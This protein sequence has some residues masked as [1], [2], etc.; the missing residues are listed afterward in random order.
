M[1]IVIDMQGAQSE[2]RFRGIG[3]YTLSFAQA[4]VRNRG[5]HEVILALSGLFP[6][7]IEPIRGAFE[8]LMPSD[9]IRVWSAP[10]PVKESD[11]NNDTRREVAEIMRE[12]FL[13]SL[14]PDLIHI[15]SV[16][17]GYLDDA[18]ISIGRF[19][20]QTPVSVTLHDLIPLLNP[21]QY[22][23]PDPQYSKYYY[24]KIESIQ[25]AHTYLAISESSREEGVMTLGISKECM[26]NTSE[27]ADSRF[28]PYILDESTAARIRRKF[29]LVQPFVLYT[30]G[31]DDRKN[32]LRLIT[33]YAR[34]PE[35]LRIKYQLL[36]AGKMPDEAVLGFKRHAESEGLLPGD[37]IFTGYIS[38]DELI[39]LYNLCELFV[40]PSWH[41]GFGLPALEAMACG[42][43]VIGANTSSLPE[44]IGLNSALFDPFEADS[45]SAKMAEVLNDDSYRNSLIDH[46]LRQAKK[47]SWDKTAK[48]A[49]DIWERAQK[50]FECGSLATAG[51]YERLNMVVSKY[52]QKMD[53]E[54]Q[55]EIAQDLALNFQQSTERQL[56]VDVSE[57]CQRDAATGIQRVVK[58]YLKCLLELP[59]SGYRV[60]PI[61][62]T[63]QEDG[64]RYAR[65]FKQRFLGENA[66]CVNDDP[67]HWQRG[68]VFLGLDMQHHVQLAHADYYKQLQLDGV[69]FKFL[70]HDLLPLQLQEYFDGSEVG[71]LHK[72]LLT[73]IASLDGAICVSKATSEA[74]E[75]W[76]NDND[77][78]RHPSFQNT[79]VHNGA[80]IEGPVFSLGMPEG[81]EQVL[82]EL[83]KRPTFLCV[84]TLEPRKQQQQILDAAQ[85]LWRGEYD[86]NLVFVGSKGWK[87]EGLAERIRSHPEQGRR[88]F[89]LEAISDEYLKRVYSA[90][91]CLIAASVNEGFG[92]S[93]V[94]AAREGIPIVARDIPVFREVADSGAY[95]FNG[96]TPEDLEKALR[97][98]LALYSNGIHPRSE[99][100]RWS[101]WKES[102]EKLKRALLEDYFPRRQLLVD[103]SEL[104]HQDARSGIQRVVRSIVKEWLD[105]P[106][107][108]FR[109]ELVYATLDQQYRYARRFTQRFLGRDDDYSEDEII[110]YSAE[111]IFFALDL[112]PQVTVAQR[113][114]FRKLRS[115]GVK[116]YFTVYDLLCILQPDHFL[117]GSAEG[118]SDWLRVVSES[119]GAFCISKA[120]ANEF[121]LWMRE[122]IV[123]P[124]GN[125]NVEWF[126]LG[127]DLDNSVP[128]RGFPA[129]AE[130]VLSR[131]AEQ[132]SFLMV[133]TVEPRKGHK[134][135]LSA[136]E[137]IW[138]SGKE[139]NLVIVGK[140]GWMVE[141]L[142]EVMRC[143]PDLGKNLFWLES[144]SDE[145]LEQ[146][147][148]VCIC[149][150]AASFGEGF[151]LPL[152]E[153]A[154]NRL[155]IIARDIPVFREVAG[156]C[157]Y[158]FDSECPSALANSITLWLRHFSE[159]KYPSSANMPWL[160]WRESA[161]SLLEKMQLEKN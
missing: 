47:F 42:A 134:Q 63:L 20:S 86:I 125:F 137:E 8:D 17:E 60:E 114:F 15:C 129:D 135:V 69:I 75:Q 133:G 40:F 103:V 97:E 145:Y 76:L 65:R 151:G 32:L 152:I 99:S 91:T 140:Q 37:L 50:D 14:Q 127:A 108:G 83:D 59:P 2:S 143:H 141:E 51:I 139:Y 36:F 43:P 159:K 73:L 71:E 39:Q 11:P 22:L 153:A 93:I 89:W 106:P 118:F 111:D 56:L 161:K 120:V 33:A 26:I 146:L 138:Q 124:P 72:K 68:D 30:G 18:V 115:R 156:E 62:A 66:G 34:L 46:G 16:F 131:L 105:N 117:P 121:T 150:I 1:R 10:G 61:Y 87:V 58:N 126:H 78:T 136:F 98:W 112:Q 12:A 102:T 19:D 70:I 104:V 130:E 57:L 144:I 85:N 82:E 5:E 41:E 110:E 48:C 6:E 94:E 160:T 84:S 109:V 142:A 45:I 79:W 148:S 96:Y 29:G 147:Y 77:I 101:T 38:D 54:Y 122:N 13:A 24:R 7:T 44:V 123:E 3:R 100:L 157:A 92:L 107:S 149:L 4:V 52:L 154:Q 53:P 158:Y 31:A 155:P 88:L 28:R 116:V 67:V 132:P 74:F 119:D 23:E 35:V 55:A 90:S 80:D 81:A 9:N 21:S 49:I 64:Y 95:Y 113:Q 27:G 128:T 25:K